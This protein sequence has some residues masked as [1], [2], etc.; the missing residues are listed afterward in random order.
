MAL[1]A[2]QSFGFRA[3]SPFRESRQHPQDEKDPGITSSP[4]PT[5]AA[6]PVPRRGT[7][8]CSALGSPCQAVP[9]S[10]AGMT[11]MGKAGPGIRMKPPPEPAAWA[12][13]A[14]GLPGLRGI[15]RREAIWAFAGMG[16]VIKQRDGFLIFLTPARAVH[17]PTWSCSVPVP[18]P[19][20]HCRAGCPRGP[21]GRGLGR[22]YWTSTIKNSSPPVCW[23]GSG[24]L[25]LQ[26][27]EHSP[28]L[29][30]LEMRKG[31]LGGGCG[32]TSGG[33]GGR[34]R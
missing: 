8:C 27:D 5:A 19:S 22:G 25:C 28:N 3:E 1:P 17:Q 26:D 12:V 34:T 16:G 33:W 31:S 11:H 14:A 29:G 32:E 18:T 2:D 4:A 23:S 9:F 6:G 24:C 10:M 13:C 7:G 20:A 15:R 30:Y 21:R